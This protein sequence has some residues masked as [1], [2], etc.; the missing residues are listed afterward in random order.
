MITNGW[1]A[2]RESRIVHRDAGFSRRSG[3][4]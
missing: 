1:K 2:S 3:R 4:S